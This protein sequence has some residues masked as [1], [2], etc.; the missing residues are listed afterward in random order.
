MFANGAKLGLAGW[1]LLALLANTMGQ[2]CRTQ[3]MSMVMLSENM[4]DFVLN[5][6]L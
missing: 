3:L 4:A 6:H 1:A 2:K 5:S